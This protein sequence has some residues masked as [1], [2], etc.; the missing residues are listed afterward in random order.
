MILQ[1]RNAGE[2]EMSA[3]LV[4]DALIEEAMT[5]T[6]LDRF[7]SE[8]YREGLDVLL[9]DYNKSEHP[10]PLLER[11]RG[12]IVQMLSDRLSTTDYLAGRAELLDR[13]VER[14]LFV[15]G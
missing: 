15:F 10:E 2:T 12:N 14:P 8:S 4:A 13:P 5:K 11:M 7:D 6:G 9:A 1:N 3:P